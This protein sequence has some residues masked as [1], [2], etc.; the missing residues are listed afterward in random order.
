MSVYRTIGPLFFFCY[1]VKK[2][3]ANGSV[4]GR[5]EEKERLKNSEHVNG[6]VD[7]GEQPTAL[8][9]LTFMVEKVMSLRLCCAFSSP[10]PQG[11]ITFSYSTK[12][13][14]CGS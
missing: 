13:N 9:N 5:E 2:R 4:G 6:N 1:P 3:E 12:G 10:S 8:K 11:Y 14:V 7:T